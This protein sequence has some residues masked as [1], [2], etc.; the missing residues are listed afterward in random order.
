MSVTWEIRDRILVVTLVGECGEQTSTTISAAVSDPKF[1][2]GTSLL[3]DVRRCTDNP[4][5]GEFRDWAARLAARRRSGL[6]SRC[7]LVIGPQTLQFGLARMAAAYLDL[8]GMEL[9]I[10]QNLEAA[11]A[12]L[13]PGQASETAAG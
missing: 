6:A 5:A 8:Q 1:Q 7:A 3:L 13:S 12:W 2:P 10:F 4:S 11:F 9:E